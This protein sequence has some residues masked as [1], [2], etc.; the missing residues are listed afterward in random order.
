MSKEGS[1][2]PRTIRLNSPL[3][4]QKFLDTQELVL[5]TEKQQLCEL[6]ELLKSKEKLF[7]DKKQ[8]IK[9]FFKSKSK[10]LKIEQKISENIQTKKEIQKNIVDLNKTELDLLDINIIDNNTWSINIYQPSAD[11]NE[12]IMESGKNII[13][14]PSIPLIPYYEINAQN[15]LLV[16]KLL[17]KTKLHLLEKYV[18]EE[19]IR[20]LEGQC[21]ADEYFKI[22]EVEKNISPNNIALVN[23]FPR[24]NNVIKKDIHNSEVVETHTIVLWKISENEIKIIDPS[25]SDYSSFLKDISVHNKFK[26]LIDEGKRSILKNIYKVEDKDLKGKSVEK[27]DCTDIAVKLGFE[28]NQRQIDYKVSTILD[29]LQQ[30][31]EQISNTSTSFVSGLKLFKALQS[32]DLKVRETATKLK[33]VVQKLEVKDKSFL[34]EL[35]LTKFDSNVEPAKIIQNTQELIELLGDL[36]EGDIL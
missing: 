28:L 27:R 19:A 13:V 32:S 7:D 26:F 22:R 8:S 36:V 31:I 33:E 21:A 18:F 1:V 2:T 17:N 10:L 9:N 14:N 6:D 3:F 5:D 15:M 24:S 16:N 35:D 29:C 34:T 23:F 11:P 12:L 20:Y 30:S 4:S 25:S